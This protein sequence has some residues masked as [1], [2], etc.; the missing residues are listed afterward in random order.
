MIQR[1]RDCQTEIRWMKA[2]PTEKN[3]EPKMNPI[4]V[5]P[6]ENG[7]LILNPERTLYRFATDE[8]KRLA[9]EKGKN[10]YISHFTT[11]PKAKERR[12]KK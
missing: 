6:A 3:P 1:C 12:K 9:K 8:E 5:A 7:N 4:E 11:C 2:V 10:L